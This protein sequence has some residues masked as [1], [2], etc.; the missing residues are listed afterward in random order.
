MCIGVCGKPTLLEGRRNGREMIERK[1]AM[2]PRRIQ[3]NSTLQLFNTLS[4][5]CVRYRVPA[6]PQF[7]TVQREL[8]TKQHINFISSLLQVEKFGAHYSK[9]QL[10][11]RLSIFHIFLMLINIYFF[12]VLK[13]ENIKKKFSIA[14]IV[15][16][17]V[18][19]C[20]CINFLHWLTFSLCTIK[21]RS[22]TAV[23]VINN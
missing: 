1:R 15:C 14:D 10:K 6:E 22:S 19:Y 3:H 17:Q 4:S 21:Y 8:A 18:S 12:F 7:G 16:V 9:N 5:Q 23:T 2:E 11:S 13:S 20:I